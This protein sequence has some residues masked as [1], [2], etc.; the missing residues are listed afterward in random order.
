MPDP[1]IMESPQAK[2]V[3]AALAG[4]FVSKRFRRGMSV[5]TWAATAFSI[6]IMAYIFAVPVA[7]YYN[8]IGLAAVIGGLIGMFGLPICESIDEAIKKL[9]IAGIIKSRFGGGND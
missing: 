7:L 9:D 8:D 2:A 5:A 6:S 3:M 4:G 1:S